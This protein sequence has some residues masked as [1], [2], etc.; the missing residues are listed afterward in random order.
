MNQ[1]QTKQPQQPMGALMS[2]AQRLNIDA[3]EAQGIIIN[4]LMKAKGQGQQVTNEE[5]VT[6]LAIASEYKLNPLTKEIYAFSNRGA[7]QPIV[8]I[9]GWLKIINGHSQFDGMEFQ[10]HLDANGKLTAVTCQIHRKDRSR[11]TEVTEYM[12]ECAGTSEPWKKWPARMLRHKATIQCA[13]YA[14]GLSGIVDPDEAERI[15]SS[16]RTERDITP[17][18]TVSAQPAAAQSLQAVITAEQKQQLIN[19]A[20]V[21]GVDETYVCQ[22]ARISNLD[23]LQQSRFGAALNHLKELS[24][25]GASHE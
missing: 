17:R 22:K 18:P 7:L 3:N 21:A 15:E 9:D 10:D 1:V 13:R 14:F 19:A 11:P 12:N 4:T 23:E 24:M 5:F 2:L 16:G 6:F 20:T 8:S 25:G